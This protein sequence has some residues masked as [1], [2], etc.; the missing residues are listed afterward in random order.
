MINVILLAVIFV[1]YSNQ[2]CAN[3]N[4][5]IKLV[6]D[7]KSDFTIVLAEHASEVESFSAKELQRYISKISGVTIPI[8][9][10]GKNSIYIGNSFADKF[11]Y[12]VDT[13]RD[14]FIIKALNNDILIAGSNDRGTL[15]GVYELLE[16]IGCRWFS[17]DY[18][19]FGSSGRELIPEK[20][21]INL[22]K[23]NIEREAGFKYRTK[24]IEEG[25][26]HTS[27]N[28]VQMVDWMAKNRMNVLSA[29]MKHVRPRPFRGKIDVV[30]WDDWREKLVP[31][32]NKRGI[33][34]EVGGHGYQN[35]LP[36]EEYFDEHPEWFGM[37][38]GQRSRDHRVVFNTSNADAVDVFTANI[39]RYLRV[40]PEI[41]IFLF[42]P[43]DSERWSQ[44]AESEKLGAAEVRHALLVNHVT[45]VL[46]KELPDVKLK[47]IAYRHYLSP[48]D[49]IQIEENT[50]CSFAAYA[51]SYQFPITSSKSR[52]NSFY[53]KV[54]LEWVHNPYFEGEVG[55][56]SYY[57]KY[58]W[59]SLP[60]VIPHLI[61]ADIKHYNNLGIADL[62]S[63]S[64]P[65]DWF[66]YELN[67]Y[68]IARCLWDPGLDID[69]MI[70]EY[71]DLSFPGAG[72][73]MQEFYQLLES[74]VPNAN[75]IYQSRLC[76]LVEQQNDEPIESEFDVRRATSDALK[77]YLGN[78][79]YCKKLLSQAQQKVKSDTQ[80]EL[81]KK[82]QINLE[83]TLMDAKLKLLSIQLSELSRKSKVKQIVE[84]SQKMQRFVNEHGE[85]GV[86]LINYST[87]I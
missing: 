20:K 30:A 68:A 15:Y 32:L 60:M 78:L 24:S 59:R 64:E 1:V 3:E 69:S 66:T 40:H 80:N 7:G 76:P 9:R 19:Y 43:P 8:K 63:Y 67:H 37:I 27:A 23:L 14:G 11:G 75:C 70:A 46:K 73:I 52:I 34:V 72:G 82:L 65:A 53:N 58:I 61:A 28:L 47:F 71:A 21:N 62:S 41:D 85:E 12:S 2:V 35:F 42:M 74:S 29:Q 13:L 57:R 84:L 5:R 83:Y 77:P 33:M 45:N 26:S 87:D 10:G 79:E 54:L 39:I 55:I 51:R 48:P 38:D 17:P 16:L 6:E 49:N 4:Q 31:E 44:D 56:Y 81:I 50:L 36:Q 25:W 86:I 22:A 18:E